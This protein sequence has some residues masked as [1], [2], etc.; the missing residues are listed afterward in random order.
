[1]R[2]PAGDDVVRQ[3]ETG[4]RFYLVGEG[5]LDV[6][7]DGDK[8][9]T[10]GPGDSFGEIAL[11]RDVPRTATVRA[12]SDAVLYSLERSAFIPAVT[13]FGPSLSA[14]EAVIGMRLG[15]GRAGLVRA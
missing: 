10:L 1:M 3:G 9:Q 8:K 11:L 15:P 13:G 12:Q 5:A 14:A 4:D 7:V 6:Y 2:V